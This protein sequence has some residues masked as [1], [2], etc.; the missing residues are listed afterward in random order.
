[1]SIRRSI[2]VAPSR[3]RS[4]GR[5][6]T[7][8]AT[9]RVFRASAT[10]PSGS[11]H[12]HSTTPL[13]TT[14]VFL[15]RDWQR[16]IGCSHRPDRSICISTTARCTT[17]RCCWT[18]SSGARAFS[19]KSSGPTT[20]AAAPGRSGRPSTTTSWSTPKTRSGTTSTRTRWSGFPTWRR[21]W[22]V[23]KRRR[24]ASCPRTPGGTPSCPRTARSAPAIRRRSRWASHG[25]S[26]RP[27]A[28]RAAR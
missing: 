15:S 27:H 11:R 17:P 5:F 2:R 28:R 24:G 3:G 23:R 1:M 7:R 9:A 25:A 13:M 18:A 4:C 26:S 16:P 8:M 6:A 12:A 10:A 14:S 22:S 20:T 19:T 21:A